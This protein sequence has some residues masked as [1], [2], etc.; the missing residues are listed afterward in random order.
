MIKEKKLTATYYCLTVSLV[1]PISLTAITK[2][3]QDGHGVMARI[4]IHICL[5][6]MNKAKACAWI[7]STLKT[8]FTKCKLLL[9]AFFSSPMLPY[10]LWIIISER[11]GWEMLY[12]EW[13]M[14]WTGERA[15]WGCQASA[16]LMDQYFLFIYGMGSDQS[17]CLCWLIST[18]PALCIVETI[19]NQILCC[20]ASSLWF[21]HSFVLWFLRL[22]I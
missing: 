20:L 5:C 12:D 14:R 7:A 6:W 15:W 22:D 1:G 10:T 4:R 2:C 16:C 11:W 19:I 13:F 3:K 21:L 8:L 9:Q 18:W 17:K